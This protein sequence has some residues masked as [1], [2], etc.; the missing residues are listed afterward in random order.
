MNDQTVKPS[1]DRMLTEKEVAERWGITQ[2][3]L[4]NWRKK[5]NGPRSMDIGGRPKY[6]LSEVVRFEQ[7][8]IKP[9]KQ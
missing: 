1:E 9:E 4:F 5:G 3:T 2:R 6:M 7:A 8:R